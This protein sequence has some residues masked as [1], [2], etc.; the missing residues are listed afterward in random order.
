MSTHN[1]WSMYSSFLSSSRAQKYLYSCYFSKGIEQAESKSYQNCYPFIYFLEHGKKYYDLA[2][3]APTEL[4]PVLL[5]YGM[6]QLLKACILTVDPGYPENSSV[7]AHGVT[8]RKR[9]KKYY[10]FLHD[11]VRIQRSGLFN[12]FSTELFHVKHAE[13]EKLKMNDIMPL[14]PEL[15]DLFWHVQNESVNVAVCRKDQELMIPVEVFDGLYMNTERFLLFLNENPA[16]TYQL[17]KETKEHIIVHS[18]KELH[19]L[20]CEPFSYHS[21][22]QY[23]L[24]G[25]RREMK[26]LNEC[27]IHY[28]V[29]YNLSMLCRYETE[30]WS[31]IFHSYTTNDLPFIKEFLAVTQY[32]VPYLLGEYLRRKDLQGEGY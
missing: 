30:W 8:T 3:T 9:K 11:E 7:L 27:M 20:E 28:A 21:N 25:S 6:I 14:I 4:Q 1:I 12:H 23:Y 13:G 2:G 29:L 18:S 5:F 17:L 22:G 32:K 10:E 24:Y 19:P 16:I 26:E 15:R 31:D